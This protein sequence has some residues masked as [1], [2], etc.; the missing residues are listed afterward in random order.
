M[1]KHELIKS[2]RAEIR[3]LNRIIDQKI[4]LGVPYHDDSR[5]HKFLSAQ[6]KHLIPPTTN[7]FGNLFYAR[8]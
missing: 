8:L 5:R 7:W 1:S 6:L 3:K 2:L 4:I